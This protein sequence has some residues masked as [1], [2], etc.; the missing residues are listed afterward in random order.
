MSLQLTDVTLTR[1]DG[2]QRVTAIDH[3]TLSVSAGELVAV[4]GP[5]G[6]GKSSLL[7]AIGGLTQIDSGEIL[8]HGTRITDLSDKARSRIRREEIGFVFQTANLLPSLTARDQL[9]LVPHLAGSAP[10]QHR[11]RAQLLLDDLGIGH[12]AHHRPNRMSSGEQQRVGLARALM[13]DPTVLL[14]DEPTGALD[15][16]RSREV[17][18]LLA[19]LTHERQI[20]TVLVTH[21]LELTGYADRVMAMRDGRL[22]PADNQS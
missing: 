14:A 6:S 4:V 18:Q 22:T 15:Y 2:D 21:N 3:V 9:L 13:S 11:Q 10:Q 8:I 1:G 12:R 16:N 5:S 17:V 19:D 20:A 7:A